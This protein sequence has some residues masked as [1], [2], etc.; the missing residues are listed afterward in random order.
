MNVTPVV[1]VV[2]SKLNTNVMNPQT[3]E[4]IINMVNEQY[5]DDIKCGLCCRSCNKISGDVCETIGKI[6]IAISAVVAFAAG[7][8][9]LNYLSFIA[10]SLNVAGSSMFILSSYLMKESS[11]QTQELNRI[12]TSLNM[13]T[14][15]DIS[16]D[17]NAVKVII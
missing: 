16:Q 2:P 1:A 5:V 15:V 9:N 12:L 3:Q 6:M 13:A 14:V 7:I 11:D 10:G 17:P 4:V 8:W